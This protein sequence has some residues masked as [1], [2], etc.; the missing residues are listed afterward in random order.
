MNC[1]NPDGSLTPIARILLAA[2][3][4]SGTFG[5]IFEATELERERIVDGLS[6]LVDAGYVVESDG[7]YQITPQG[8][9]KLKAVAAG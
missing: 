4:T 8:L 1:I 3:Q 6:E 2:T 9:D 7:C 5:D